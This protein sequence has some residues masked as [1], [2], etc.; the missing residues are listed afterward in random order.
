MQ[1]Y[2]TR[3]ANRSGALS[4]LALRSYSSDSAAI[5]AA[6]H[7][8]KDGQGIEIWRGNICVYSAAPRENVLLARPAHSGR[9]VGLGRRLH[10]A[11]GCGF[12]TLAT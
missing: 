1:E 4:L 6:R 12:P 2:E 7:I 5:H 9:G 10:V 3:V 8:C 11:E